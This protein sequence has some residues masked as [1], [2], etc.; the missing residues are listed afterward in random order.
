MLSYQQQKGQ[1][2]QQGNHLFS[3]AAA[4]AAAAAAEGGPT[5]GV[6]AW[7]GAAVAGCCCGCSE[8]VDT[9]SSGS[10]FI[11]PLLPSPVN[12]QMQPTIY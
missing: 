5:F 1:Q 10:T 11:D 6:S 4:G 12:L 3:A 8:F 9:G 7:D 2:A